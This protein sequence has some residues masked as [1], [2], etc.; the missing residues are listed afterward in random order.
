MILLTL[1]A[2]LAGIVTVLSP[3]IFPLLPIILSSSDTSGKQKPLGVVTG[4]ILSFTFFTLFLATIVQYSGIPADSLRVFAVF[5]LLIFGLSLL[6][7]AIQARIEIIF[8]KFA[9]LMPVSKNKTGFVG[10]V[11]IGISLGLLWTPCVGP[12]LASVISLAIT[13]AVT[14]QAFL[15]TLAYAFGTGIPMLLIMFAGSTALKKVPWLVNNTGRI[16]KGFGVLMLLTAVCIFFGID[17]RFQTYILNTFPN[18]GS[19]LTKF[20]DNSKVI[21]ELKNLK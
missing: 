1:F 18:Y 4:F 19:E 17:R 10:G 14:A 12:I 16:Q 9:N 3:C 5:V 11:L 13:G 21:N 20:E 15:I 7:N 2:F 6:S 8:S